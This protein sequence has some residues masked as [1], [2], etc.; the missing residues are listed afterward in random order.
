MLLDPKNLWRSKSGQLIIAGGPEQLLSPDPL[1]NRFDLGKDPLAFVRRQI[2]HAD[3]MVPKVV[4]K[5]VSD[6]EGY[7]RARQAFGL[8]FR[9]YWRAVLFASRFP[10]GV[11]DG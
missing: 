10:G 11:G 7:Q 2:Q 9:E 6:G 1:S 4:E 8:L 5:A 3:E